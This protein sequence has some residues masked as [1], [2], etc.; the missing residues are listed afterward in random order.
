MVQWSTN[1]ALFGSP[2]TEADS[3]LQRTNLRLQLGSILQKL[4]LRLGRISHL[5][6][7]MENHRL[8]DEIL[9]AF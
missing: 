4:L 3:N 2:F 7:G 5:L 8:G 9:C 6:G 1:P